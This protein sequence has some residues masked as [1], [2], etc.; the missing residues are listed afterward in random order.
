MKKYVFKP[1]SDSFLGLFDTEKKRIAES[2]EPGALIE[3]IGSTAVPDLGGKG[4]IDI[5]IAVKKENLDKASEQLQHLGYEFRPTFSTPDRYFFIIDLPDLEEGS[6]RYHVHLT[7]PDN[8]EW[9]E[10]L[11]FRD[12]LIKHPKVA[13]EYA[14]IKQEAVLIANQDGKQ[15]RNLKKSIIDQIKLWIKTYP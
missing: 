13:K 7:Y 10:F 1:Y 11:R 14:K 5:A 8:H 2:L 6:R 15:Y 4:I 12:Y 3:H 9:M